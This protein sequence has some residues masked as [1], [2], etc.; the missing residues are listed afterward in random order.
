MFGCLFSLPPHLGL[1][2]GGYVNVKVGTQDQALHFGLTGA[3]WLAVGL[4]QGLISSISGIQP[5]GLLGLI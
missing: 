2:P 3:Q 4:L 1:A 5:V